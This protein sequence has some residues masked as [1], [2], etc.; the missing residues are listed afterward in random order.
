MLIPGHHFDKKYWIIDV[1]AATR[2]MVGLAGQSGH[3]HGP[4]SVVKFF[5]GE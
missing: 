3:A 1:K 2:S 4:L 5:T